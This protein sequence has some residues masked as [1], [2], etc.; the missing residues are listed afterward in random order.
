[1]I[2]SKIAEMYTSVQAIKAIVYSVL[3]ECDNTDE[4][5]FGRGKIHMNTAASVMFASSTTNDILDKAVQIHGGMGYMW[6]SEANRLYRASKLL[7]IGAGTTEV[8]KMI[9]S[10]ELLK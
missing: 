7:D 10:K 9:I 5:E 6:E 8:R 4:K 3:S 1:M 2:Q